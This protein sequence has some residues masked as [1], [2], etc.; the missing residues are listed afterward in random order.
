MEGGVSR[1][2]LRWESYEF[3]DVINGFRAGREEG[4]WDQVTQVYEKVRAVRGLRVVQTCTKG[5]HDECRLAR[6]V[7]LTT[8]PRHSSLITRHMPLLT[9]PLQSEMAREHRY[10]VLVEDT[11]PQSV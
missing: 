7:P 8:R 11:L 9:Y 3:A 4:G 2:Q 5:A 10:G 6:G 1:K